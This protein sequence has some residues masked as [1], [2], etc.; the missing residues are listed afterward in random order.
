MKMI[1]VILFEVIII[2]FLIGN[3]ITTINTHF[4]EPYSLKTLISYCS[5]ATGIS[6]K[7]IKITSVRDN[8]SYLADA[9]DTRLYIKNNASN[10][11]L[12]LRSDTRKEM[13][14]RIED[15]LSKIKKLRGL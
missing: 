13:L 4:Y 6:K 2:I 14:W 8:Q 5:S 11:E 15:N 3:I 12:V 10:W 7:F 9:A 1:F